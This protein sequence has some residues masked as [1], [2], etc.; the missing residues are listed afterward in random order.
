MGALWGV[1]HLPLFAGNAASAGAFSPVLLMAALLFAWLVPYRVLMVWLYDRTQSLL[2]VMLMHV[3]IVVGVY[4]FDS[5]TISAQGR[6]TSLVVYGASLWIVVG[7]VAV[8][9]GGQLT[10]RRRVPAATGGV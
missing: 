10:L 2:L 5:A 3:P 6:F 8:A 4:V 7:A 1:W 9:N